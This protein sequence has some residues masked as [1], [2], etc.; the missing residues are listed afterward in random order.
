MCTDKTD[1]K[2]K[3]NKR[4]YPSPTPPSTPVTVFLIAEKTTTHMTLKFSGFYFVSINCFV[5]N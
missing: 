1:D 5:K 3:K 4:T 2:N